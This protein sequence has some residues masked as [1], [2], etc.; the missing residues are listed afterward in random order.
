MKHWPNGYIAL[1]VL[2]LCGTVTVKARAQQLLPDMPA[3]ST[4]FLEALQRKA[5]IM[6]T[7]LQKATQKTLRKL[8]KQEAKLY[9]A[10]FKKD[11]EAAT[12]IFSE[13]ID[14]LRPKQQNAND[15][16]GFHPWVDSMQTTL[17]F[18][19]EKT[20]GKL[21]EENGLTKIPELNS[22]FQRLKNRLATTQQLQDRLSERQQVI[23][24]N[25]LQY[26]TLQKLAT[27]YAKQVYYYKG[28][29][30]EYKRLLSNRK[31]V[32]ALALRQLHKMPAFRRFMASNSYLAR[33]LAPTT[34]NSG[35]YGQT[36]DYII[37]TINDRGPQAMQQLQASVQAAQSQL[38]QL[39]TKF[40]N[41]GGNSNDLPSFKANDL[42]NKRFINRWSLSTNYQ[43]TASKG[44]APATLELGVQAA[45]KMTKNVR[46]GVGV[47]YRL[48][49]GKGIQRL[50][51]SSEGVS[52]RSF[53]EGR[54]KGSLY[55]NAGF[56]YQYNTRFYNLR[57]LQQFSQWQ[58]LMLAGLS[59]KVKIGQRF[60]GGISI[61][62]D[63]LAHN[64]LGNNSPWVI[65]Y[66]FGKKQ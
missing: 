20:V 63:F 37:A 11:A 47:G 43:F 42:R 48:G 36:N 41:G 56:E 58:P 23:Q 50:S 31:K 65:R 44:L 45:Y 24:Q 25:L 27:K 2:L 6:E 46:A 39:K 38:E 12:A 35:Y 54:L 57:Q 34:A 22:Q 59:K 15:A 33:L 10:L 62:Y 51:F 49:L 21:G 29:I 3:V 30:R 28:K 7:R 8:Q 52:L 5:T 64:Q 61:L 13:R 19:Q 4:V 16:E 18:L 66:S 32:E 40:N 60:G 17:L 1:I 53:A 9:S 14:S 26:P 55:I